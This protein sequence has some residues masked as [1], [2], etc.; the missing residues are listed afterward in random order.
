MDVYCPAFPSVSELWL[1]IRY[2]GSGCPTRPGHAQHCGVALPTASCTVLLYSWAI[3]LLP[4]SDT[5]TQNPQPKSLLPSRVER[6]QGGYGSL[7]VFQLNEMNEC[8]GVDVC[9]LP[10]G[11]A[12]CAVDSSSFETQ[13]FAGCGAHPH[14]ALPCAGH[15]VLILTSPH[16]LE[17]LR[18]VGVPAAGAARVARHAAAPQFQFQCNF[19]V[20]CLRT[21]LPR[22]SH[23]RVFERPRQPVT[24]S[25]GRK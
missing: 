4:L 1:G 19:T 17:V 10:S 14:T 2:V 12:W 25:N 15:S 24:I 8:G 11:V 22:R 6:L 20:T 3:C 23:V 18:L 21:C 5:D 13:H 16:L 9:L 7:V